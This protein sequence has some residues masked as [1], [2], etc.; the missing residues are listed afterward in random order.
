MK[1]ILKP[2]KWRVQLP[3]I[4]CSLILLATLGLLLNVGESLGKTKKESYFNTIPPAEKEPANESVI[5]WN[6]LAYTLANEFD[7]FYSFTGV[8]ALSMSHLAIHDALNAISPR[9]QQYAFKD[10]VPNADPVAASS[11]AA[12]EVLLAVYPQKQEILGKELDKWL[13]T[14][15]DGTPK[16]LGKQLGKQAAKAI[17]EKRVNDGYNANG[18]YAPSG[19]N[20][21]YQFTPGVTAVWIPDLTKNKPFALQSV[22]QFRCD[23]PPPLNSREYA[24]SLNEVKMYGCSG[25][26]PR[27]D[28]QTCI[29]HWWAEFGEHGWNRIGRISSA[30]RKLSLWE[31][32]RLFALINMNLYDLYLASFDSKYAFNTWRPI[33]AIHHADKDDNPATDPDPSWQ[34]EMATPP[35]PEYPSAHAAVGAGEAEIVSLVY[36]TPDIAFEME[37][38]AA[39]PGCKIRSYTNLEMA[40]NDCADSRIYNGFHFRFATEEGKKQGR[41]I[42]K[43]IYANYLEPLKAVGQ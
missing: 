1:T 35:W 32:A 24:E 28:E 27:N 8:R 11:L 29:A 33:T 36:G 34:P 26:K 12:Y 3:V 14:V 13:L 40:A 39:L 7:Q 42:A 43:Y 18:K 23:P 5:S 10:R 9:Y 2:N 22:S 20:G 17:L 21:A 16:T 38:V 25:S 30:Q 6:N 37:S 41:A 19:K 15:P 31:T 4:Y